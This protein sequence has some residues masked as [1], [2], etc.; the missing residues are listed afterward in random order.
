M[1]RLRIVD[2]SRPTIPLTGVRGQSAT[3]R[4]HVQMESEPRR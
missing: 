2:V 3:W 4:L 1:A